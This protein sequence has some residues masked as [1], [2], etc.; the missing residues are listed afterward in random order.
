MV[1]LDLLQALKSTDAHLDLFVSS[2]NINDEPSASK[3]LGGVAKGARVLTSC[4]APWPGHGRA[5]PSRVLVAS[6]QAGCHAGC[7]ADMTSGQMQQL[8][9]CFAEQMDYIELD[10][11]VR[12]AVGALAAAWA[13]CSP[14]SFQ[15][16]PALHAF[17]PDAILLCQPCLTQTI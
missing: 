17:S 3:L 4:G 1:Y 15:Q 5:V 9:L 12:S 11:Q 16:L 7:A 14:H 6:D 8:K 13:T 10:G 2:N